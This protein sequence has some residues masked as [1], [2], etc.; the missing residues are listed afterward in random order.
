VFSSRTGLPCRK[1]IFSTKSALPVSC[2]YNKIAF[3]PS[4]W[5]GIDSLEAECILP[6]VVPD[7]LAK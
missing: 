3:Q 6:Q 2:M 4:I 1:I 5:Y 7:V